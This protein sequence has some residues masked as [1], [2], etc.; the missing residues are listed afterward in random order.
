[1]NKTL[2]AIYF[3]Y[4]FLYTCT[5]MCL[6][7]Y[8]FTCFCCLCIYCMSIVWNT[9]ILLLLI[10]Y[11][12]IYCTSAFWL[13]VLLYEIK[14]YTCSLLKTKSKFFSGN[15]YIG[16]Q[17]NFLFLGY[18]WKGSWDLYSQAFGLQHNEF[19]IFLVQVSCTTWVDQ[20]VL[21]LIQ[22]RNMG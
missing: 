14:F 2:H 15:C 16:S 18:L 17:I 21:K 11:P 9:C 19:H 20:E 1:M 3:R 13:C 4:W 7:V 6:Y 22:Y 8:I 10:S 12:D 5:F